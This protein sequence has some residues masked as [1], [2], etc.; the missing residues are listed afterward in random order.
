MW[1]NG[2]V[3]EGQWLDDKQFGKGSFYYAATKES[4]V[5]LWQDGQANLSYQIENTDSG[6]EKQHQVNFYKNG[7]LIPNN[8]ITDG[9]CEIYN[10][11]K[12]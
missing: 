8:L 7:L 2:N 4:F 6:N 3:Y 9:K 11:F 1:T 5:G 12:K 10:Y